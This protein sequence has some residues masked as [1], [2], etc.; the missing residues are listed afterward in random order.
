MKGTNQCIWELSA[1]A[2]VILQTLVEL[3]KW[4]LH[5]FIRYIANSEMPF[6][7]A[8]TYCLG[9]RWHRTEEEQ[10]NPSPNATQPAARWTQRSARYRGATICPITEVHF[11]YWINHAN[12]TVYIIT[13]NMKFGFKLSKE[14]FIS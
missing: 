6:M 11:I 9:M 14:I 8:N 7:N 2:Y 5:K 10:R 1:T 13:E 4:S 3:P 12:E